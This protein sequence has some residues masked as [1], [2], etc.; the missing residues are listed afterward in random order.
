[1]HEHNKTETIREEK[2]TE[3]ERTR[4]EVRATAKVLICYVKLVE[5]VWRDTE[6]KRRGRVEL[7]VRRQGYNN[8][9]CT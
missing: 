8:D 2:R 9:E 1:M 3:E 4:H 6:E 7:T 5:T